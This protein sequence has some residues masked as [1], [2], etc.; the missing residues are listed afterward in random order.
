MIKPALYALTLSVGI[1]G[2]LLQTSPASAGEVLGRISDGDPG[3]QALQ[4][5]PNAPLSSSSA[6]VDITVRST[7]V[8]SVPLMAGLV[9]ELELGMAE[10]DELR[11]LIE[12]RLIASGVQLGGK[13]A[14]YFLRLGIGS[15]GTFALERG[16]HF[17]G[18]IAQESTSAFLF[19]V[20]VAVDYSGD[21][22]GQP[23]KNNPYHI[24]GLLADRRGTVLWQGA[25]HAPFAGAQRS[26]VMKKLVEIFTPLIGRTVKAQD[27]VITAPIGVPVATQIPE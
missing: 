26:F 23:D 13:D 22:A 8:G 19:K 18:G 24:D 25:S 7:A 5:D 14:P 3:A 16:P 20:P 17:A 6:S 27:D 1:V 9:V 21:V 2:A 11:P 4:Q 10:Q 12:Q 15:S